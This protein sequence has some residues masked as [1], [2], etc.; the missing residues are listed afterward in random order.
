MTAARNIQLKRQGCY[1]AMLDNRGLERWCAIDDNS[2]D[3]MLQAI[4]RLKLSARSYHKILKLARSIADLV[5]NDT[6]SRTEVA[7]AISYRGRNQ[8]LK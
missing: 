1:N 3:L 2:R 4:E 5:G 6:I 8:L 7:E